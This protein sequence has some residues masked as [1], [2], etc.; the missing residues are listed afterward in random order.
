V[1]VL[2]EHGYVPTDIAVRL[3]FTCH[4]EDPY[5]M[6]V[7]NHPAITAVLRWPPTEAAT[8][9]GAGRPAVA[10]APPADRRG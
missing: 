2:R 3:G 4:C 8:S 10:G 6:G 7:V 5:A 1:P 9:I